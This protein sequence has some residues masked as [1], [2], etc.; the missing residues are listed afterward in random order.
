MVAD[1]SV[2]VRLG[3]NV[4]DFVQGME[5]AAKAAGQ[6][7][8][9]TSKVWDGIKKGAKTAGQ[10]AGNALNAVAAG[11]T[12]LAVA[13]VKAGV[14]YNRLQQN[15]KTAL[16]TL[17][18]S[19]QAAEEQMRRLDTFASGSPFGK[20]M[21]LEAQQVMIG[22]GIEAEKVVPILS[23][24][25]DATVATGG[26][27]QKMSEIVFVLS[28]IQAAGKVTGTDLMQLGQ[29]GVNAAEMVGSQIG[30]TG[31]EVRQMITE[32]KLS[33]EDFINY[34]TVG[35]ST[36]FGGAAAGL[37][38]QLD[39]A[40]DRVKAARRDIG[41]LLAEPL[42]N[43]DGG[44]LLVDWAN[45]VADVLRALQA[46]IAKYQPQMSKA[47]T[48]WVAPVSEA[49]KNLRANIESLS[50]NTISK[51]ME[52]ISRYQAPLAGV[53]ASLSA[54]A[55]QSGPL[56]K[57]G[58]SINPV[59]AGLS[60]LAIASPQVREAFRG[61]GAQAG[62]LIETLKHL[63]I[64]GM[65]LVNRVLEKAAPGLEAAGVAA[66]KLG[67]SFANLL[68]AATPL[69]ESVLLPLVEVASTLASALAGLPGPVLAAGAAFLLFRGHITNLL[70]VFS[71][72][73]SGI[74]SLAG[75]FRDFA[76]Y[77]RVTDFGV[78]PLATRIKG[79]LA[80]A[81]SNVGGIARS[82][83]TALLGAFGGPAGLAISGGIALA[84]Y[85]LG[86]YA[87]KTQETKNA[88][89]EM[90][91][92]YQE[93]GGVMNQN[94]ADTIKAQIGYEN[95]TRASQALGLSQKEIIAAVDEG[96]PKLAEILNQLR[97]LEPG[98]KAV[99][100][101][102]HGW[103]ETLDAGTK[104][105]HET[106]KAYRETAKSLEEVGKRTRES[107][108]TVSEETRARTSAAQAAREQAAAIQAANKARESEASKARARIDA[109]YAEADARKAVGE[110]FASGSQIKFDAAGRID[111]LGS[112]KEQVQAL[113][114][115]A[116]SQAQ[117][118]TNMRDQK[119]SQE[120]I[121]NQIAEY[122]KYWQ[123]LADTY[124]WNSEQLAKIKQDVGYLA[125]MDA[126]A[127]T[128][129][130][131]DVNARATVQNFLDGVRENQDGIIK[132]NADGDPAMSKFLTLLGVVENSDGT[133]Q[134]NA[135]DEPAVATLLAMISAVDS[136]S[137]TIALLADPA[138]ANKTLA[139]L[140]GDVEA[141]KAAAKILGD[142]S[143]ADKTVEEFVSEVRRRDDV[144]AQLGLDTDKAIAAVNDV[145]NY[146]RNNPARQSLDIFVNQHQNIFTRKWTVDE[147][148][149][150]VQGVRSRM[151]A[152]GGW[153]GPGHKYQPAGIV[154]ANEFVFPSDVVS[155]YGA[156]Y[157]YQMLT[158]LRGYSSGGHVEPV[159]SLPAPI[160]V[161]AFPD[162]FELVGG[163][164]SG[165]IGVDGRLIDG[166]ISGALAARDRAQK[167]AQ[168]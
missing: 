110:L 57:L 46:Q 115:V 123:G 92:A 163:E 3:A 65:E 62:P 155:K 146:A 121:N 7:S 133:F 167:L 61:I 56:A 1:R 91:A 8:T 45:Q 130:A 89:E 35:M 82:A 48:E 95:L 128:I 125:S 141:S 136:E 27:A 29:R 105:A 9:T 124:G 165:T 108:D 94:V 11:G 26:S 126:V 51:G 104:S 20:D 100:A 18:G 66:V 71:R 157:F 145:I 77:M 21:L 88:L 139:E 13:T 160:P 138:N 76:A 68:L 131:D 16:E 154:H 38:Q 59:V 54:M 32:G 140:L 109:L 127:V 161:V 85:A 14:D 147:S 80:P 4:S 93:A 153:T 152:S 58:L 166:R 37:K 111:V 12:A 102:S 53:A 156:S 118:L 98:Y 158:A 79:G 106:S 33:A 24:V 96:G 69:I 168:R 151:Y 114:Q 44:G 70:P 86:S 55:T 117:V 73:G 142:R 148:G 129:D 40:V 75:G 112:A 107:K 74:S 42:V 97:N 84:T 113:T 67:N 25:Q 137:G 81:V 103:A 116:S 30:K 34:L 31:A 28:Q 144:R 36:A 162:R 63:A 19:T 5:K 23:A 49:L 47:F 72:V 150:P 64:T 135:N 132:I 6:V 90:K 101:G 83:G 52:F 164:I 122:E 120:E 143:M 78:M 15:T 149:T 87:E 60:A 99:I 134:L 119:K 10:A 159:P 41:A 17:L 43:P 22:F 50:F 2:S 39:G